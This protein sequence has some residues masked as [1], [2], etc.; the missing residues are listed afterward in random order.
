LF[1]FLPLPGS[2]SRY[3]HWWYGAEDNI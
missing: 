3:R 1:L 2:H